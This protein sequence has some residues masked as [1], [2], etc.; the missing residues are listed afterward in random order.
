[1]R[2]G[3][4][5]VR[6]DFPVPGETEREVT[7]FGQ[8]I[9]RAAGLAAVSPGDAGTQAGQRQSN[10]QAKGTVSKAERE[11]IRSAG[12]PVSSPSP[13]LPMLFETPPKLLLLL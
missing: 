6:L 1:M 8:A 3:S 11:S 4:I 9:P 12:P 5:Q 13:L 7:G 2:L 10:R